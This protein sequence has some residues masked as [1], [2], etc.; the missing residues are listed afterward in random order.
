MGGEVEDRTRPLGDQ[1]AREIDRFTEDI[2]AGRNPKA[3]G[4]MGLRD[5][6][7]VKAIYEAARTGAP[8]AIS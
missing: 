2:Q 7:I 8:V 3:S 1:F 5:I 4:E 6:K